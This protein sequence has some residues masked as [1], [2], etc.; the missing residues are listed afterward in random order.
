PQPVT[1]IQAPPPAAIAPQPEVVASSTVAPPP[2]ARPAAR[3]CFQAGPFTEEQSKTLRNAL[4]NHSLPPDAWELQAQTSTGRWM[5]YLSQ[6]N[7]QAAIQRHTELRAQKIDVDRAGG[8]LEPGLSLGRFSS[9]EAATRELT[10]LLGKG[11][12]GA[13]IVQERPSVT[14][15]TLRLPAITAEQGLSLRSLGAALAGE[16]LRPC[17]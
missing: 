14:L 4:R 17:S 11:L 13:R 1:T 15:Y 2:T 3:M 12:R 9:E 10:R 6:P 5:V 16:S 7:V 8:R